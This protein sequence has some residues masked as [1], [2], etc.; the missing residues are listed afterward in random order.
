[1]LN[2]RITAPVEDELRANVRLSAAHMYSTDT[3]LYPGKHTL[4]EGSLANSN[5]RVILKRNL[6][7]DSF[8]VLQQ[9][10]FNA[11][12]YPGYEYPELFIIKKD[13]P[14]AQIFYDSNKP[15]ES[16]YYQGR[17]IIDGKEH[18]V[19]KS[20]HMNAM[21]ISDAT[22]I[23]SRLIYKTTSAN[24]QDQAI[25]YQIS[26]MRNQPISKHTLFNN[27]VLHL[28]SVESI[29]FDSEF[30]YGSS[31]YNDSHREIWP[32]KHEDGTMN[33]SIS[34]DY[35]HTYI[36]P[37]EIDRYNGTQSLFKIYSKNDNGST[38]N[39]D[40]NYDDIGT[41]NIPKLTRN[42]KL[43]LKKPLWSA[44]HEYFQ[45]TGAR[46]VGEVIVDEN[47]GYDY[48]KGVITSID[49]DSNTQGLLIPYNFKGNYQV[50]LNQLGILSSFPKL[51]LTYNKTIDKPL[52]DP[53]EGII[54][55]SIDNYAKDHLTSFYEINERNLDLLRKDS[56]IKPTW[57][58]LKKYSKYVG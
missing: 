19:M 55:L 38:V 15:Y 14:N 50:T 2:Y 39:Y 34:Y 18:F 47:T 10:V 56:S 36:V 54:Q 20:H 1:M 57:A 26:L 51:E 11:G 16:E 41:L 17:A 22:V 28:K 45:D 30:R 7:N 9:K 29:Y 35:N 58:T 23:N 46:L 31:Y 21:K 37:Q 33:A 4:S 53:N 42:L 6:F 5:A 44:E 48:E 43:I 24:N 52:L 8:D 3:N 49:A 40:I 25:N 13:N 27:E 12:K 32:Y